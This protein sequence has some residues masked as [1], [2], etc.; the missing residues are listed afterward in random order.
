MVPPD[1]ASSLNRG[2]V[3]G[4][5]VAEVG[6]VAAIEEL[7]EG[8]HIDLEGILHLVVSQSWP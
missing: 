8:A 2:I 3:I 5:L 7:L 6:T 4:K 1:W